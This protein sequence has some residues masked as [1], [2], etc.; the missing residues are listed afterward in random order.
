LATV[1]FQSVGKNRDNRDREVARATQPMTVGAF[2]VIGGIVGSI[3]GAERFGAVLTLSG[4]AMLLWGLHR[5][6]RLGPDPP[7]IP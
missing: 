5:L 3:L 6:G 1:S 7:R 4:L 2:G